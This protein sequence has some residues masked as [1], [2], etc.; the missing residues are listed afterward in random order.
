M[1]IIIITIIIIM[2]LAEHHFQVERVVHLSYNAGHGY[3]RYCPNLP[4]SLFLI[5]S[6]TVVPLICP[7]FYTPLS[8][9]TLRII[10]HL[11]AV[12]KI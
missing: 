1:K 11:A 7:F 4:L 10:C 5:L 9:I 8:T 3:P 2:L 6:T 12:I